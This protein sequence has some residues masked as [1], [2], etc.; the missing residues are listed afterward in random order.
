MKRV[1][2]VLAAVTALSVGLSAVAV[3]HTARHDSTVTIQKKKNGSAPD[4]LTGRVISDR[5]RCER[6]RTIKIFQE[7][8]G[9]DAVRIGTTIT[10]ADGNWEFVFAGDAPIGTYYAVATRE[11][12]RQST[13]HLHVCRRAVSNTVT[14]A[15]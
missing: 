4:S 7:V 5:P 9:A 12:L 1:L 15:H 2:V 6:D 13:N 10:D 8:S 14:V 11:V 3:A